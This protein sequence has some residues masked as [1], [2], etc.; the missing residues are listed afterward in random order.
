MV[1]GGRRSLER[2]EQERSGLGGGRSVPWGKQRV[3]KGMGVPHR[4]P[5][6]S[7]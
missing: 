5:A 3:G 6:N 7:F 2:G 4:E 1:V